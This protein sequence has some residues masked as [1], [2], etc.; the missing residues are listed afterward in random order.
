MRTAVLTFR[1]GATADTFPIIDVG[2]GYL[3]G[4]IAPGKWIEPTDATDSVKAGTNKLHV[5]GLTGDVGAAQ[6]LRIDTENEYQRSG[7]EK[8]LSV[9][10][11]LLVGRLSQM[12]S[13]LNGKTRGTDNRRLRS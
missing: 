10:C 5:Y 12:L 6:V 13:S 1:A 9:G 4:A 8:T 2:Y 11:G 3:I 7:V